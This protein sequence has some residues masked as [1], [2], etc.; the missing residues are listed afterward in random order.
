MAAFRH[1]PEWWRW[2][3]YL[4][5]AMALAKH[6]LTYEDMRDRPVKSFMRVF[7]F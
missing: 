2:T 5:A 6:G 3:G 1:L 4:A 7:G